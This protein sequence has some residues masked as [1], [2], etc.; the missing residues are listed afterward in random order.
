MEAQERRRARRERHERHKSEEKADMAS[1]GR[2]SPPPER[3]ETRASTDLGAD[4]GALGLGALAPERRGGTGDSS[5]SWDNFSD[6]ELPRRRAAKDFSKKSPGFAA[7]AA[8]GLGALAGSKKP[9]P[10]SRVLREAPGASR[11]PSPRRKKRPAK[12]EAD[13][14]QLRDFFHKS[15]LN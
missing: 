11:S 15:P 2:R 4:L 12:N 14:Q 6:S 3:L 10:S 1:R 8:A 13:L 7:L 5:D 9:A